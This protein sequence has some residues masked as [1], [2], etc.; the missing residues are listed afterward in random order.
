L[1]RIVASIKRVPVRA[2]WEDSQNCP[3]SELA[4]A[5]TITASGAAAAVIGL[6]L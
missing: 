3:R 2:R 4:I 6:N 1:C 5:S